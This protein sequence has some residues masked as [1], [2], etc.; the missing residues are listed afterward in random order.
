[1]IDLVIFDCDGV[2]VNSE[3]LAVK[4]DVVV[5]GRLGWHLTEAEVVERFV[6]LSDVHFR[7]EIESHIG[8]PLPDDWD[9]E[10]EPLYRSAFEAELRPV[11][12]IVEVLDVIEYR[13]CVASSGSHAKMRFTLGLTGLYNR[14]DGRIFSAT[15]VARGKPAP[16]VFLYAAELM[17]ALPER[18]VVV[19][20]S[21]MGV[22]AARAAGMRV[23]AYAGGVTPAAKL[24][25]PD[26]IL[27]EHMSE[28]PGLLKRLAG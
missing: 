28:L 5:L 25:G 27:F 2:L 13:T 20:D 24:R 26:T 4:V 6:G 12:G 18:C 23:L 22:A 1:M 14:F 7:R 16:D 15:E 21:A 10:V 11:E 3:R 8:R 17:G 9:A 19:E